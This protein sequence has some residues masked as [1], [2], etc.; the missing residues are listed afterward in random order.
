[1]TIRVSQ[2]LKEK[3]ERL[4]QDT[5]RSNGRA[6]RWTISKTDLPYII[7]Y[8][9]TISSGREVVS[10]LRVIHMARNLPANSWPQ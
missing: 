4:A 2:G 5:R 10:I 3:F 7:A 1:M 9:I 8:A 6:L